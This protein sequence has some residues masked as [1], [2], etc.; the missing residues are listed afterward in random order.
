MWE[1]PG[2][3][4]AGMPGSVARALSRF[5]GPFKE[6]SEASHRHVR[7]GRRPFEVELV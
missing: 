3:R 7:D 5:D 4:A 1:A 6:R 2:K